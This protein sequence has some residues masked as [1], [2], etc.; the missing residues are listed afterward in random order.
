[1]LPSEKNVVAERNVRWLSLF[2]KCGDSTRFISNDN[3]IDP[4]KINFFYRF[5]YCNSNEGGDARGL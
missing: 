5:K 4:K 1:M 2:K 3:K